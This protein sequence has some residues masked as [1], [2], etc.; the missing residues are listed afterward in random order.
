MPAIP[1]PALRA[2]QPLGRHGLGEGRLDRRQGPS[3][4]P[5]PVAI[6]SCVTAQ[7]PAT[8][9]SMAA[10]FL[11]DAGRREGRTAFAGRRAA[12]SLGRTGASGLAHGLFD[13]QWATIT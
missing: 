4:R 5:L 10:I 1:R 9:A 12:L 13:G 2:A 7:G 11:L 8:G 6:P 3:L